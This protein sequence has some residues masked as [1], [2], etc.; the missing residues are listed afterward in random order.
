MNCLWILRK[1]LMAVKANMGTLGVS[2]CCKRTVTVLGKP[3][4]PRARRYIPRH[5]CSPQDSRPLTSICCTS[6]TTCHNTNC[7]FQI[8]GLS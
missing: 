3:A 1:A 2:A 5:S 7:K 6:F 4:L 8:F